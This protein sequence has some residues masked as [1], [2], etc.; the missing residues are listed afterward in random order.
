MIT[1]H[2][3]MRASGKL[4]LLGNH[5]F[6]ALP[7]IGEDIFLIRED[8]DPLALVVVEVSHTPGGEPGTTLITI[9]KPD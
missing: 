4:T 1:A 9:P 2:I 8:Q 3:A 5:P 6:H 7:R